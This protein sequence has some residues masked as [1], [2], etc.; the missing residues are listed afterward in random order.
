MLRVSFLFFFFFLA[1]NLVFLLLEVS[2]LYK[3]QQDYT[4]DKDTI[5]IKV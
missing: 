3:E 1:H 5:P 2:E 4:L